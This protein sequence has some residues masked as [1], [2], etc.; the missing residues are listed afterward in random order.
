MSE[1]DEIINIMSEQIKL[2][3]E[4]NEAIKDI[5][6]TQESQDEAI[7]LLGKWSHTHLDMSA[8]VAS[9]IKPY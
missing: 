9:A 7:R 1:R 5:Q 8:C 3:K 2:I 4:I 6:K